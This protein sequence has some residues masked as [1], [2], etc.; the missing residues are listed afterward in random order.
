MGYRDYIRSK[1]FENEMMF[2]LFEACDRDNPVE[3]L[4]DYIADN[5]SENVGA[6]SKIEDLE[7]QVDR[8]DESIKRLKG[9]IESLQEKANR[10]QRRI[11]R[12]HKT[13]DSFINSFTGKNDRY[14]SIN[15]AWNTA[16]NSSDK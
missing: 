6:E 16:W 5:M 8:R 13:F 2:D 14:P 4:I 1:F 12:R 3:S 11:D 9:I 7:A 10:A 15:E